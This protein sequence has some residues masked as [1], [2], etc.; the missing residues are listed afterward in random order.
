MADVVCVAS[1]NV[2]LVTRVAQPPARGQTLIGQGLQRLPGG[3]GSNA[4]VACARQGAHT[5]VVAGIGDDAFGD[6][7]LALWQHE[8]IDARHAHRMVGHP[9]GTA[10][11]W[12]YDDGDNSIVVVPGA[13]ALLGTEHV[14]AAADLLGSARVVMGSCEVP[15]SA[16]LEAFAL[17]RQHGALTLFNPA[18][19]S[20]VPDELWPLVDVLSPNEDE[21][22]ALSGCADV[23]QGAQSLLARGVGAVVVTLGAKGCCLYR[24]GQ[25]PLALPGRRMRVVDTVGAGDTFTGAL[26]AAL[27]REEPWERALASANTAAA[28]S[29][30][31]RGA[32]A[33]M[34]VLAQVQALLASD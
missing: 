22:A 25:A 2:D 31:E 4:A 24:A 20:A 27:A 30:C 15:A 3:K 21:L 6:M 10:L 12:V 19:A 33:G 29:T 32:L 26:A 11:I 5:A 16:L 18:P 14:R 7:A 8:G 34:P 1:W 9:S 13:N 23:A 28:L 17:A